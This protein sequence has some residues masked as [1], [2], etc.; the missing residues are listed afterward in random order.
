MERNFISME[1]SKLKRQFTINYLLII[2]IYLQHSL[3]A[4]NGDYSIAGVD[5]I[6][7]HDEDNKESLII[8]GPIKESLLLYVSYT[9]SC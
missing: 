7:N 9:R 4:Q 8:H 5:A 3:E 6:Y 1:T 2:M